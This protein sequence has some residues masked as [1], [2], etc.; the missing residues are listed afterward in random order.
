MVGDV[1]ASHSRII[2]KTCFTGGVKEVCSVS[3]RPQQKLGDKKT[4]PV[5][6]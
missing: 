1:S 4:G 3:L 2:D 6:N 5:E